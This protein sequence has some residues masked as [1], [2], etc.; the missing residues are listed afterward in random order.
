MQPRYEPPKLSGSAERRHRIYC[1]VIPEFAHICFCIEDLNFCWKAI[2]M[3]FSV[4]QLVV[5]FLS[6]CPLCHG[7]EKS[8]FS[9]HCF[10][11]PVQHAAMHASWESSK[12]QLVLLNRI[13]A[14]KKWSLEQEMFSFTEPFWASATFLVSGLTC[15]YWSCLEIFKWK[16]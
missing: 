9:Q 6:V 7:S 4:D 14:A 5:S 3:T 16:M 2:S 13:L 1:K 8:C 10:L 11:S 12:E 15:R